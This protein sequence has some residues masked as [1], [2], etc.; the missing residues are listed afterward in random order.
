MITEI[1]IERVIPGLTINKYFDFSENN[2][3][4]K[5]ISNA[6]NSTTESKNFQQSFS[7]TAK[8]SMKFD[9]SKFINCKIDEEAEDRD[10]IPTDPS[11]V[12]APDLLNPFGKENDDFLNLRFHSKTSRPID[13]IRNVKKELRT[14]GE[15][16]SAHTHSSKV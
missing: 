12:Y 1:L 4:M 11:K 16:K 9:F 15:N 3:R 13:K 7:S 2:A 14:L 8:A 5:S 6:L 10:I